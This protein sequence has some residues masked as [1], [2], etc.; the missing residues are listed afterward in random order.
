MWKLATR[1][2]RE[3]IERRACR[4]NVYSQSQDGKSEVKTS[5]TCN[6]NLLSPSISSYT[7]AFSDSKKA[8]KTKDEY[9]HSRWNAKHSWSEAVGWSSAL[10]VGWVVC[11]SLMLRRR[12]LEKDPFETFTTKI[13]DLSKSTVTSR[14]FH[15][16]K[17]NHILPVTNCGGGS[18]IASIPNGGKS[19]VQFGPITAEEALNEVTNE[20]KNTHRMVMG[21]YE[22]QH[23]IKAIEEKRYKDAKKHFSI[24]TKLLSPA[25]MFN[26]GLCYELGLGT[27][28]DYT[29]AAK[30]YTEAAKFGHADAMYNL[31]VFY[32]Q[33]KGVSL[34][35]D[36]ARNYFTSAAKLGQSQARNALEMEKI[37]SS[38]SKDCNSQ[39]SSKTQLRKVNKVSQTEL[40][41]F[42][43]Y[44][45]QHRNADSAECYKKIEA[46]NS[47]DIFLSL[48]GLDKPSRIPI[49]VGSN[50]VPC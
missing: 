37:K 8:G 6:Q 29:Q 5:F 22:L 11:Q 10:A 27:I 2:I 33:G 39:L 3:T 19:N 15:L 34:N 41:N 50:K 4:T 38:K 36:K 47:T 18:N 46:S 43:L 16:I 42:D 20:F 14:L 44:I 23:G 13:S 12:F 28:V 30:Y 32:A 21:E 24:G 1:G 31:G 45:Q 35:L 49:L 40:T 17:P 48:L 7:N 25:S 9:C 26:L